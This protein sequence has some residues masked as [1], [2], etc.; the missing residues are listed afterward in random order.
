MVERWWGRRG[1]RAEEFADLVRPASGGILTTDLELATR[2][3]GWMTQMVRGTPARVQQSLNDSVPVVALIRVAPSRYHYVVILGWSDDEVVFHD[4]AVGPFTTLATSVFLRRWSEADQWALIVR[5]PSAV[6]ASEPSPPDPPPPAP[7]DSLPCRPWLDEAVSAAVARRLDDA[8]ELL[9]V[10]GA[11]CPAEPLVLRELAGVRFRQGREAEA[12]RLAVEYLR[13]APGDALGWQLLASSRYLDGDLTGALAAW[14]V[15][16]RP[17]V[18]LVRIDGTRAIRYATIARAIDVPPGV[19]L[20]PG[21]LRLARRR[22]AD[23][24][25]LAMANVTYAAVSG[26]MVELRAAVVE[27]PVVPSLPR[28]VV[29][30]ALRAAVRREVGVSLSTPLGAGERWTFQYR[31]EA[32]DPRAVIRLDIPAR[33]GLPGVVMVEGSREQY[34]FDGSPAPA[35]PAQRHATTIGFRGWLGEGLE[36]LA[37]ARLERWSAEGSY[38]VLALG[39]AL[40][41]SNDRVVLTALAEQAASLTDL[42]PYRRVQARAAWTSPSATSAVTWAARLGADWTT[43]NTPRGL[44]PIAGGDLAR[45]IPLRAHPFIVHDRLPTARTGRGI[46]HGGV[47]ADRPIA[48][49][50]PLTLD[51]GIF[52]DGADVIATDGNAPRHRRYVDAGAGLR[53]GLSGTELEALRI[54]V[55]RGLIAD[56]RW[57]L[58]VGL[59]QPWPP[60]LRWLR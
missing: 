10:A 26:G 7:D 6:A 52:L 33:I 41:G 56:R 53:I 50:G 49:M 59:Q 36:A 24:P 8:A 40:H 35:S 25:A 60:R 42:H 39:G 23:V 54:D 34:R 28:L 12:V 57:G 30:G 2:A 43:V 1:V 46:L 18:D 48:A 15:I 11:T 45:A 27:R 55:A 4:P 51:A 47:A 14:N 58:S 37:G 5:P 19:V 22:I 9:A 38:V 13:H 16:G 29:G 20:T 44:W 32:A 21:H 3:R 17:T 31:W